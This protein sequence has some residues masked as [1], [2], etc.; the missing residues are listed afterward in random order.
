MAEGASDSS[1]S[2]EAGG[3]TRAPVFGSRFLEDPSRVYEHNAWWVD[4]LG[5]GL[6]RL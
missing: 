1:K 6:A 2:E 3:G 4:G 5:E